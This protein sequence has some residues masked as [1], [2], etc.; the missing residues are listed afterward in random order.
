MPK[1]RGLPE[2]VAPAS[3]PD[4]TDRDDRQLGQR[5]R[6]FRIARNLSLKQLGASVGVSHQQVQKY[7]SGRNG[8]GFLRLARFAKVLGVPIAAF[9]PDLSNEADD[10]A[11]A[12]AGATPYGAAEADNLPPELVVRMALS[13]LAE[14]LPRLP[15]NAMMETAVELSLML[16]TAIGR[17]DGFARMSGHQQAATGQLRPPPLA[18]GPVATAGI[19]LD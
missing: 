8:V 19:R 1:E 18:K 2:P 13:R 10:A 6:S 9:L 11:P 12:A 4:G 17:L 5:L 14:A 16:A 3:P 7:E 15:R